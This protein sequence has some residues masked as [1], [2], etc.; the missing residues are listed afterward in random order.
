MKNKIA[1]RDIISVL[2]IASDIG[3]GQFKL[4]QKLGK[5]HVFQLSIPQ[6]EVCQ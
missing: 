5:A 4:E 1:Q 3:V 2:A 6:K